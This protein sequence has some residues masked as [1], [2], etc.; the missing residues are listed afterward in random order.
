[1]AL[2]PASRARDLQRLRTE[3]F[4]VVVIGGGITGAGAF[5]EA[6]SRGY[7]AALIES[8]DFASGTSSASSKLI[9]GGLR[10]L[11]QGEVGLVYENLAE[12]SLLLKNAPSLVSKLDF[13]IPIPK[14]VGALDFTL[15]LSYSAVLWGYDLTGGYRIRQFHRRIGAS[16]VKFMLPRL[17]V[18]TL[19]SAFIY[20]DAWC[21]D[22]RLV[23]A[24]LRAARRYGAVA[25]NYLGANAIIHGDD[26]RVSAVAVRGRYQGDTPDTTQEFEIR[27]KAV[28]NA[29]GI[30]A[31]RFLS[32]KSFTIR[33]AKG[34]HIVF[35]QRKLPSKVAAV[36]P[37]P[38][39]NRT[40]FL[41]PW[42]DYTYVGT[43]DTDL[44]EGKLATT[45]DDIDYLLNAVNASL[46]IKLTH[47]DITGAWVGVRP[48]VAST[49]KKRKLSERTKDL[50]RRHKIIVDRAGTISVI[51]GKLTTYRKMGA[52]AIDALDTLSAR[53][54]T[55]VSSSLSLEDG[56]PHSPSSA[57]AHASHLAQRYGSVASRIPKY[58]DGR[59]PITSGP[60]TIQPGE[61]SFMVEEENALSLADILLR[62]IR[63]GIL[64]QAAAKSLAPSVLAEL[65]NKLN[66]TPEESKRSLDEFYEALRQEMPEMPA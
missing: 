34:V 5:L 55:S 44:G 2:T 8:G 28:I 47:A 53:R 16:D 15:R 23:L 17:E 22:V 30:S 50:S 19:A 26:G 62:R 57:A 11:K 21:D 32:D 64:D 1:M 45:M 31:E 38:S 14:R 59:D 3:E 56:D 20:H 41:L 51:G 10:Y 49:N 27:T 13:V 25:L 43:T 37:V 54:T 35:S 9:H 65:A 48:L 61:I 29:T 60:W 33:P 39:D 40:I 66:F 6:A 24:T 58:L 46:D 42:G 4:D 12:R 63:V 52:D 18:E 36:L 7:R